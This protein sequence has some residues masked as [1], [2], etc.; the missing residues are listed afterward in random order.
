LPEEVAVEGRLAPVLVV[1]HFRYFRSII[2]KTI[3]LSG[4]VPVIQI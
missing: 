2:S 3:S 4:A 1:K